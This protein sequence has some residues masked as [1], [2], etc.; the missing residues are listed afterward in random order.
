MIVKYTY[1]IVPKRGTASNTVA[2]D[3]SAT[4]VFDDAIV[5]P[6]TVSIVASSPLGDS[7]CN[8]TKKLRDLVGDEVIDNARKITLVE[9]EELPMHEIPPVR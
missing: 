7:V 5:T 1:S 6:M 3:N 4:T 8:V 9:A 2:F